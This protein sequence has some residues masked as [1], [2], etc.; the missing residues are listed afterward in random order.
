MSI[1]VVII[2]AA[3]IVPGLM[4]AGVVWTMNRRHE[5][6]INPLTKSLRRPPGAQ[7]G[8]QLGAAFCI[9]FQPQS[10]D[11]QRQGVGV[12]VMCAHVAMGLFPSLGYYYL[13]RKVLQ[14]WFQLP[15]FF[16]D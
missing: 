13:V 5:G 3:L 7:L 1:P 8:R 14:C 11:I 15:I 2:F 16:G 10:R 9:G 6:L 4:A 12:P